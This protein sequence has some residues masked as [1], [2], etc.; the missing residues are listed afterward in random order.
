MNEGLR[1]RRLEKIREILA[2]GP[3][4]R[5][6]RL[7]DLLEHSGFTVTQSSISRDLR[8]LAVAKVSGEYRLPDAARATSD[9]ERVLGE[10]LR[11][12]TP[13]GDHL[14]V[15]HTKVG[16]ASRVALAL[17]ESAWT[18]IVGTVAGDDTIFLATAGAPEQSRLCE[19]FRL[20]ESD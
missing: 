6:D 9:I 16:D 3:V 11:H 14:L 1:K 17:D 8:D 2:A 5:Q 12:V 15:L 18:E 7:V 13:A 19:R 10:S 20:Y 4:R